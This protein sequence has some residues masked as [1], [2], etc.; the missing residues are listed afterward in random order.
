M[1]RNLLNFFFIK[2]EKVFD[3]KFFFSCEIKKKNFK[4][5]RTIRGKNIFSEN[6]F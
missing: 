3:D 4:R 1:V 2:K 6:F 5:F